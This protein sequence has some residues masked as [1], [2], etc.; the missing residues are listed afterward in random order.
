MAVTISSKNKEKTFNEKEV[1]NIGSNPGCDYVVDIGENFMLTVQYNAAANKCCVLNNFQCKKILFKGQPIGQKLEFE[2]VCKLM[3]AGSDEFISIKLLET[4][5]VEKTAAKIA[6]EDFTESDLKG[7]YG[8]EVNATAR[9]KLEKRK[10]D[11][12]KSRVAIVKQVSFA[13][14]D[15]RK[16]LSLNFKASLFVHTAMYLASLVLAFGVS[17]YLTGLSIEET[18]NFLHL[19]TNIKM[20]F[21]FSVIIYGVCLV[22]KQGAYLYLQNTGKNSSPSASQSFMLTAGIVFAVGLYAIN[23]VYYMQINIVFSILISL[24]FTALAVV[25][26]FACGYF[27]SSGRNMSIMLDKYEY[28][29]D[30]ESVMNEYNLWIERYVNTI[31]NTKLRNI[32]DKLF[33]LQ[34]K[35]VGEILLGVITAP[36]LAYGVSNT[37]A[38]CF[39]EAAGWIRISGL[40]FSPVF[41]VLATFLIIF[42]FF[43]FVNAFYCIRKIQGSNVI[44]QDGFSNYMSHGVN[45]FGLE[46]I[47]KLESEKIRSLVIGIAIV[48]IE[49]SMNTSYFMTEIGGDFQGIFLSFVAALVPTALLIAE[50]YMLS[51][52]KF[53]IYAGEELISRVDRD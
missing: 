34:I 43:A 29:E 21:L 35:S 53:D 19:P 42:A 32:K 3:I 37:L 39:P 12:E 49:F 47:R 51:Q 30:F 6:A 13:L 33:N 8:S 45:I 17:N 46:G 26:A 4:V 1:I 15:L 2:K 28:R 48:C 22:L 40:R 24:F 41:L 5:A 25:F 31:S 52:T 44:K 23:L 38:M 18:S 36:F 16:R 9:V 14:N 20:L 10:A 27:K 7:L 11:L 50:T